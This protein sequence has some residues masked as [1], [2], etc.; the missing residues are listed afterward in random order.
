MPFQEGKLNFPDPVPD[1][2][3]GLNDGGENNEIEAGERVTK[4]VVEGEEKTFNNQV[5]SKDRKKRIK[6]INNTREEMRNLRKKWIEGQISSLQEGNEKD[7]EMRKELEEELE[8]IEKEIELEENLKNWIKESKSMLQ[9]RAKHFGMPKLVVREIQNNLEESF[10]ADL[11]TIID[12]NKREQLRKDSLQYLKKA[13]SLTKL[14]EKLIEI[15]KENLKKEK[16]KSKMEEMKKELEEFEEETQKL[17]EVK[18]L[19]NQFSKKYLLDLLNRKL[20]EEVTPTEKKMLDIFSEVR[21]EGIVGSYDSFSEKIE[22]SL[23]NSKDFKEYT[24][25]LMHEFTH[26]ALASLLP[27]ITHK[28]KG[29]EISRILREKYIK[30]KREIKEITEEG[31]VGNLFFDFLLAINESF[32]H[33]VVKYYEVKSN[34]QYVAYRDKIHPKLFEEV[35]SYIEAATEGKSLLEF[36]HMAVCIYKFFADR[37]DKN[38]SMEDLKKAIRDTTIE[39]SK[40]KTK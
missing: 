39:I 30:D 5:D 25:T 22:I 12:E 18:I 36:D 26:K 3:V 14:T 23:L 38:L 34:P 9:Q 19:F 32:A 10:E 20:K 28:K 7:D 24:G 27:E 17:E 37:W 15:T 21:K 4:E 16:D 31:R 8:E 29:N 33:Q 6:E 11:H 1:Q 13:D 2:P 40:F 35:Y